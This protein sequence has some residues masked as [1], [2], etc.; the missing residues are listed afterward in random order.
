MKLH[1]FVINMWSSR[2][3]PQAFVGVT[4]FEFHR[5]IWHQKTRTSYRVALLAAVLIQLL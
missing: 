1:P 2:D 4:P 5:Y 3:W